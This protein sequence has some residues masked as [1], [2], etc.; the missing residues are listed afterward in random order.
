M[1]V[2]PLLQSIAAVTAYLRDGKICRN[3]WG[4]V[5]AAMAVGSIAPPRQASGLAPLLCLAGFGPKASLLPLKARS[6]CADS[7]KTW[8]V[9]LGHG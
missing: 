9:G 8:A 3:R 4:P 6:L 2:W 7:C 1:A 5:A